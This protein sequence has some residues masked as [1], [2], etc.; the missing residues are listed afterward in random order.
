MFIELDQHI[1][2]IHEL[3]FLEQHLGDDAVGLRHYRDE[4]AGHVGIV[5]LNPMSG[6]RPPVYSIGQTRKT[7]HERHDQQPPVALRVQ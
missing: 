1:A 2:S 4:V 5:R 7:E 6:R 3:S